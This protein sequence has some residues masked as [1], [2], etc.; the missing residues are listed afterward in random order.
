MTTTPTSGVSFCSPGGRV[1]ASRA[2]QMLTLRLLL[3]RFPSHSSEAPLQPVRRSDSPAEAGG[4]EGSVDA[5][6][7]VCGMCR[8]QWEGGL[9]V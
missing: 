9:A 6:A 7:Q 8:V 3:P 4:P 5:Q 1:G 2:P